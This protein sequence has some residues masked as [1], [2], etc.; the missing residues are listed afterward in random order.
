[1]DKLAIIRSMVG[2]NGDHYAY[3]CLTGRD[4]A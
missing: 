3:Q 4:H 2:A 1:M